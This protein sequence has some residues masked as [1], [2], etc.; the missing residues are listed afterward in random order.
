MSYLT[1]QHTA[2]DFPVPLVI[3]NIANQA[4]HSLP[5][6]CIPASIPTERAKTLLVPGEHI[7]TL[8]I[9]NEPVQNLKVC[10]FP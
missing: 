2:I 10:R 6:A 3:R 5:T 1:I 9:H 4:G 8:N 7:N